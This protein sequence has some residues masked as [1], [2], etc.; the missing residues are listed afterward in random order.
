[1]KMLHKPKQPRRKYQFKDRAEA[2]EQYRK[3]DR[4][5]LLA[6]GL[7]SATLDNRNVEVGDTGYYTIGYVVLRSTSFVYALHDNSTRPLHHVAGIWESDD[8]AL[9]DL[10]AS[11]L[12]WNDNMDYKYGTLLLRA[13]EAS[14]K[15]LFTADTT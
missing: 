10:I 13:Q 8:P 11:L 6:E 5:R 4:R 1:M 9:V 14:H 15:A 7:L 2:E 12:R 3:A